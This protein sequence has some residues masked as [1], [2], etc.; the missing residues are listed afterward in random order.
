MGLNF[1]SDFQQQ[2]TNGRVLV[3][4][5]RNDEAPHSWPCVLGGEQQAPPAGGEHL[6]WEEGEGGLQ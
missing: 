6:H 4:R 2:N 1:L 3:L 5:C